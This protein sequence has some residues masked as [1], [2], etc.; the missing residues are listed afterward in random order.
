MSVITVI[1]NSITFVLKVAFIK[2]PGQITSI[3]ENA[4]KKCPRG[5]DICYSEGCALGKLKTCVSFAIGMKV[6]KL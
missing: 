1:V 2:Y 6:I 3:D 5:N 4:I